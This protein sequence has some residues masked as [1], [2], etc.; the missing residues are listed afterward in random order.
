VVK[1]YLKAWWYTC[2]CAA[3]ATRND[4]QLPRDLYSYGDTNEAISNA[5]VKTFSGH[6]WYL[7]E[8]LVGLAFFDPSVP[9]EMKIAMVAALTKTGH[10]DHR[11]RIVLTAT[12]IQDKQMCDF[13]S[14]YTRTLFTAL[15]IPHDFLIHDPNTWDNKKWW[16]PLFNYMMDDLPTANAV[17]TFSASGV[18]SSR[19]IARGMLR[20]NI[21][22]SNGR[23]T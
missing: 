17:W 9:V 13:A 2:T 19:Y 1:L 7:S 23:A 16:W 14:Q 18:R 8:V 10:P 22:Q 15:D 12:D 3:S 6:L 4:L 11:R 21:Q 5:A 20:L